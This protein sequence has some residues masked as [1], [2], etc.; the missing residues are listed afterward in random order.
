MGIPEGTICGICA[1]NGWKNCV[2]W[3]AMS[4]DV[5][6]M[7]GFV[8]PGCENWKFFQPLDKKATTPSKK[9]W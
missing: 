2:F 1:K 9:K 8:L 3:L 6:N 7:L 4:Q 5:A